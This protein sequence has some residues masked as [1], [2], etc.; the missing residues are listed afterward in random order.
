L[1]RYVFSWFWYKR[2]SKSNY[3]ERLN[4]KR[5]RW[6]KPAHVKARPPTIYQLLQAWHLSTDNTTSSFS[7]VVVQ[8][9][10]YNEN[11]VKRPTFDYQR[12]ICKKIL[13]NFFNIFFDL[14][15]NIYR[16]R[17][18]FPNKIQC[19]HVFW[20]IKHLMMWHHWKKLKCCWKCFLDT[21]TPMRNIIRW[22]I[23]FFSK[24][25]LRR[26]LFKN[27]LTNSAIV[28]KIWKTCNL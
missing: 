19:C 4:K 28:I 15:T 18:R 25:K 1:I 22:N 21:F 14:K 16:P 9:V 5:K 23:C 26:P 11:V 10:M 27:L 20:T 3:E 6:H 8:G 24:L 13:N 12:I 7:F 2:I 17:Y